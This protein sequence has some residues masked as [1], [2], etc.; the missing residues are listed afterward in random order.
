MATRVE[1]DVEVQRFG[2][3]SEGSR[4]LVFPHA[5]MYRVEGASGNAAYGANDAAFEA[6][7]GRLDRVRWEAAS[8]SLGAAW[9]RD[10]NGRYDIAVERIEMPHGIRL[11]RADRGIEL[12]SPHVSLSEVRLT[13]KGPFSRA[14]PAAAAPAP[15]AKKPLRQERLRFLDSVSGRIYLTIKVQL[16]LPVLGVRTLDQQLR[17][18]IQE[19]SL[20]FRAL[21]DSLDWLEGRVLEVEHDLNRLRVSWKVP[22]VGA[23]HDLI[24]W[25]LDTDATTLAS[26][27]RVPLR[28]L[29]DFRIANG[30]SSSAPAKP[31]D[32]KRKILT[33]FTLDAI[34]IALS[35]LAPRSVELGGGLVM[36]GGDD[37]P[38]IVD[39]KVT[40]AIRAKGAGALRGAI[41]SI[42]TTVKD[43]RAGPLV[44]SA[45][46]LHFDGLDQLEVAF[47][48]FRPVAITV[49]VHRVT[50]TNLALQIVSAGRPSRPA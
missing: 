24:S 40:G 15:A 19:G 44:V 2:F 4:R 26:F 7:E 50:A 46:R 45:D 29:A 22:I 35:L 3:A 25:A 21:E 23:P 34:D 31:D 20:D 8:A 17:V 49:V 16:D 10:A 28:A 47:D 39:L 11:V 33:A 48:G 12:L 6:L 27:G 14:K 38:G 1:G 30:A 43:L 9:L 42:D 37:Q 41:G 18:P 5:H 32:K 13:V 36:F